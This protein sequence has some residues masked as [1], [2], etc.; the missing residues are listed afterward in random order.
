MYV[1]PFLLGEQ[2]LK[3]LPLDLH[4]KMLITNMIVNNIFMTS[5]NVF[6]QL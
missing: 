2:K 1:V 4:S 6:S 5:V 3:D